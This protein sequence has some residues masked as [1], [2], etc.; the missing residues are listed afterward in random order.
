MRFTK[1]VCSS[2]LMSAMAL[3]AAPALAADDPPGTG[4]RQGRVGAVSRDISAAVQRDLGLSAKQARKQ[5]SLQA[6]AI[7]LDRQLQDSLGEA[8]AGSMYDKGD[9]KLVVMVSDGAQLD[10][11][12]AAGAEARLVKHR[13]AKLDAIKSDLDVAAGHARSSDPAKR[14]AKREAAGQGQPAVAGITSWYVDTKTNSVHVTVKEDRTEAAEAALAKYGD[15]VTVEPSDR[16]PTTTANFMDGGDAINNAT[17]SAGFN[18]RNPSTGVRYLLSAGHCQSAGSTLRGQGGVS[19]GRVLESWFPTYDDSL[20]RNDNTGYWIQGPWVDT[21]PSNGGIINVSGYTD[22][23]VNTIMC[24]SGI[25][26]KWTCGRITAKDETVVY[27]GT[28]TVRGLTRH[29]AC[30]EQG[31]SGGANV[32]VTSGYAAEGVS[33]GAQLASDGSRLRCLSAFGQQNVS[34]YFPIADSLAYYGP[35]YGVSVW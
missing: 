7:K 8:Y 22:A 2:V 30:V 32:S 21:N 11:A 26:T 34:W 18:L 6:K 20:A 3:S 31:D 5:G 35:K 13:K 29:S 19:F 17:C 28:K 25:T 14:S 12:R 10:E 23:P 4:E 1:T 15:A 27:D 33:S 24:K 16:S 9:G